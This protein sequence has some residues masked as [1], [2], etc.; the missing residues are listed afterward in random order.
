MPK[1]WLLDVGIGYSV[2]TPAVVICPILLTPGSVNQSAP[3]GP[4]AMPMGPLFV[5]VGN[6]VNTP[7]VVIRPI[8]LPPDSVNQRAPSE[9]AAM[10]KPAVSDARSRPP[11]PAT[12]ELEVGFDRGAVLREIATRTTSW[13][14]EVKR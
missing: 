4:A 13:T 7:S 1:G 9:P 2:I 12:P 5:A 3:S 8:L 6:S 10:A 14:Q 11:V